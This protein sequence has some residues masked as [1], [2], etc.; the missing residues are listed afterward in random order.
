MDAFY[1]SVEQ[2]DDPSLKGKPVIVGGDARRG[3]VLAA[4]YE[5]RPF[6]VRSAMSMARA[7]TLAP[8]AIVVPPRPEAYAEASEKVFTIFESFTP[9]VE[10]LSLDEAFLDV[11]NSQALFGPAPE[12]AR[13]LRARIRHETGLP[14]SAG[15]AENKF[16]AKIASDLAKP[17]GFKE[18]P[19]GTA[20]QFLAPLPVSR[21]WGV[22]P[23]TEEQLLALGLKTIGDLAAKDPQ[24]LSRKLG[25][26]GDHFWHLS[27]GLDARHVESDRGAKSV[28]A[29]D[30]FGEDLEGEEALWPHLHLQALRVARRMRKA[31]LKART[32]QLKVKFADF[33]SLTRRH[34]LEAPTDDGQTLYREARAL[35]SKVDLSKKVRL[36]G[37]SAQE[38]LGDAPQLSLFDEGPP[39]KAERLNQALD[40]IAGK[41]GSTAVMPADV[42]HGG[43][44]DRREALRRSIGL[45][46]TDS[47]KAKKR[48]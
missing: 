26:S 24:W 11:T 40:A 44:D 5:V 14:A 8:K 32:V 42:K 13:Q 23:K 18:V 31:G 2:R 46:K 9:L 22:G 39:K 10:G 47:E 28:G 20:P 36:T 16:V 25:S 19:F 38:I 7:M 35:L 48:R 37:V 3:V 34:T 43:E 30:T 45:S 33:E 15:L 27:R 12:I 29:E 1:A 17:D 41:F 6:G 21:L 4:S